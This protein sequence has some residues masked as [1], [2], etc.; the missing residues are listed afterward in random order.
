MRNICVTRQL[1]AGGYE[2]ARTPS[3]RVAFHLHSHDAFRLEADHPPHSTPRGGGTRDGGPNPLFPSWA[4]PFSHPHP[5]R[6][7]PFGGAQM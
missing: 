4:A 1:S 3:L 2:H 7:P 5:A 6:N